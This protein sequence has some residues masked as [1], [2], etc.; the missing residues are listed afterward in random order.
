MKCAIQS[1]NKKKVEEIFEQC[2]QQL[3]LNI[4][5][6]STQQLNELEQDEL[7]TLLIP[8]DLPIVEHEAFA[9]KTLGNG[10]C[11]FNF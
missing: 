2:R 6:F 1:N 8:S 10:N 7:G 5:Q 4:Y 11:L 3:P 9:V